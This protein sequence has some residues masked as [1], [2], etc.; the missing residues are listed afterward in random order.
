M[1]LTGIAADHKSNGIPENSDIHSS[2]SKRRDLRDRLGG[3]GST[4]ASQPNADESG[5]GDLRNLLS[6]GGPQ[7]KERKTERSSPYNAGRPQ[8]KVNISKCTFYPNCIRVDCQYFHPTEPCLDGANCIKGTACLYTHPLATTPQECKFRENCTNPNCPYSHP[9][10]AALAL[11]K[12]AV[13]A[14]I[15]CRYYPECLN[16]QCPFLHD[17]SQVVLNQQQPAVITAAANPEAPSA[18]STT[19]CRF[20]P[21]CTR[22]NC[23]YLHPS[24]DGTLINQH[25][26]KHKVY[27][28]PEMSKTSDRAFAADVVIERISTTMEVDP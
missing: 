9:S 11:A 5:G 16:Q 8:R 4:T 12:A 18:A 20:D 28:N 1:A 22:F 3:K 2:A 6:R 25:T 13:M 23:Y 7:R 15:P 27:V 21:F 14:K 17:P 19:I 10:P 26:S 24:K